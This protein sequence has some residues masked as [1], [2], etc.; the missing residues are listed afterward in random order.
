[1][2]R[3]GLSERASIDDLAETKL[4]SLR[5]VVPNGAFGRRLF[6]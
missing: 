2:D 1:M 3:W 6:G 4:P 5:L